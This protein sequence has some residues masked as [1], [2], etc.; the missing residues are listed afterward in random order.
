M[1]EQALMAW[2]RIKCATVCTFFIIH[3]QEIMSMKRII[4]TWIYAIWYY[5][6]RITC[7]IMSIRAC[8][9][10]ACTGPEYQSC[11]RAHD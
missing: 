5:E 6:Q 1:V 8:N 2:I 11:M 4:Y 7:S 3:K 9:I 10:N